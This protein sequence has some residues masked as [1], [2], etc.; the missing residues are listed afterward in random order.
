[1][2]T[3]SIRDVIA[4]SSW[5]TENGGR[6]HPAFIDCVYFIRDG[7]LVLYIGMTERDFSSRLR[8]HLALEGRGTFKLSSL[9][10]CIVTNWPE[11]LDWIIELWKPEEIRQRFAPHE[12]NHLD[13]FGV[14]EAERCAIRHFRP[15]LNTAGRERL[16]GPSLPDNYQ[17]RREY[18]NNVS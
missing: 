2:K 18:R 11:S 3:F 16:S 4:D 7:E 12:Q 9:G 17:T 8:W 13:P 10:E 5:G 1:M 15:P 6:I 14:R